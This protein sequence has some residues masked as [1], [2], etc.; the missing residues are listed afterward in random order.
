MRCFQHKDNSAPRIIAAPVELRYAPGG[1]EGVIT[2]YGSVFGVQDLHGDTVAAGAFSASLA[3]H[4]A[5]GTMPA[6]LWQ[7]DTSEPIGVWDSADEDARGLK[8][9]GRLNLD[10]SRGRE[11]YA[12]VKQGALNGLSIGFVTQEGGAEIDRGTGLRKLTALDLWEVSLVTFPSNRSAR[13]TGVKSAPHL[14][15]REHLETFLR[16]AGLSKSAARAVTAAGWAGLQKP[17]A[18]AREL[19]TEIRA[20][21]SKLKEF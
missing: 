20:F 16:D 10:T 9:S 7:H 21:N 11:A 4:K 1:S 3:R 17:D 18:A 8:L 13:L 6:L 14:V 5:D 2:G 12:L 19:L 15:S